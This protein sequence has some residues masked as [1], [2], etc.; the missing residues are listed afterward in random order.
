MGINESPDI[1]QE[2]MSIPID[3]LQFVCTYLD[4]LL[5]IS[6]ST[7]EDH[8]HQLSKVLQRLQRARLKINAE[9][10]SFLSPEIEYLGYLLIK[11][12]IKPVQKKI[13]AV[14]DLQAPTT[15]KELRR[16][17]VMVRFYRDIWKCRSHI[18]APL[19][20]LV[21]KVKRKIGW[22]DIHQQAFDDIKKV[23]A[24]ETSLNNLKFDRTFEIYT[25]VITFL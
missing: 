7:F 8:L 10:S 21:G 1:F 18:L 25:D 23:M 9:R 16:F 13:Q 6:N 15:L 3:G 5:V 22:K 19:I 12:G 24:K 14:L 4:D 2:K 20:D 17:L 11:E